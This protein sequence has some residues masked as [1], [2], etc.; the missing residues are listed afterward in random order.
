VIGLDTNILIR[1][2]TQDD[3]L[4]APKATSLI[5]RHLSLENPG[6]VSVVTVA[7]VAWVLDR[8]YSF[9]RLQIS[10]AIDYILAADVLMVEHREHV[11]AA[12]AMLQENLGDFADVLI[13]R[14][15]EEAGCAHTVTF[16][17][18]AGRLPGFKLLS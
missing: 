3:P 5:E 17:R 1:Y 7:E 14:L 13:S 12:M 6:Y 18:R 10:E 16:D 8:S 4:L 11:F 9:S 15:A 2:L